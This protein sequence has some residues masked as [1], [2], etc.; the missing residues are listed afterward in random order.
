MKKKKKYVVLLRNRPIVGTVNP[1]MYVGDNVGG[2]LSV[3]AFLLIDLAISRFFVSIVC[4]SIAE[5]SVI[6]F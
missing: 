3:F 5:T 4:S 2:C 6:K 1:D